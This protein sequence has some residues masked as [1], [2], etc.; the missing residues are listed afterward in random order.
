MSTPDYA[1]LIDRADL[2]A[3]GVCLGETWQLMYANAPL[4]A[5]LRIHPGQR[6]SGAFLDLLR[7][8]GFEVKDVAVTLGSNKARRPGRRAE[9]AECCKRL[10]WDLKICADG[11]GF[12]NINPKSRGTLAWRKAAE[13]IAKIIS[14][15]NPAAIFFPHKNGRYQ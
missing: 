8:C 2:I 6:D 1:R 5:I 11:E 15:E 12:D 3:A 7:E 4:A 13:E 14:S 10:S 9:L